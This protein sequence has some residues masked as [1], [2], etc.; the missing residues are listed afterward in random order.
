MCV[1]CQTLDNRSEQSA[2]P[3]LAGFLTLTPAQ[4]ECVCASPAVVRPVT[5]QLSSVYC[6]T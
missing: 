2:G 1:S 3:Q 5:Q 4:P 6:I